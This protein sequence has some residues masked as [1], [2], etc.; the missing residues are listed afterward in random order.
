MAVFNPRVRNN[1]KAPVSDIIYSESPEEK[2]LVARVCMPSRFFLGTE[3]SCSFFS[4]RQGAPSSSL[5]HRESLPFPVR[6]LQRDPPLP[7]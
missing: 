5:P 6:I 7:G 1:R 3:S 4:E 2:G